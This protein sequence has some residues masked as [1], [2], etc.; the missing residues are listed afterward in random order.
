[1]INIKL[2]NA[3]LVDKHKTTKTRTTW[4]DICPSNICIPTSK[5]SL[6]CI[7]IFKARHPGRNDGVA[8]TLVYNDERR[9]VEMMRLAVLRVLR[10]SAIAPASPKAPT[11]GA[12]P[13]ASMQS[14]VVNAFY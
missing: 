9:S 7:S 1:L 6:L 10:V 13:P 11:V 8:Q 4:T 14:F 12:L 5:R 2:L 3:G